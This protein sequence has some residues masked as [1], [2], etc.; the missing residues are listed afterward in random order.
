MTFPSKASDE[1]T[2]IIEYGDAVVRPITDIDIPVGVHS[3]GTGAA[4][5]RFLSRFILFEAVELLIGEKGLSVLRPPC[6]LG[7]CDTILL[8]DPEGVSCFLRPRRTRDE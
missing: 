3:A 5:D 8:V 2:G 6:R 1:S 7:Y 4:E